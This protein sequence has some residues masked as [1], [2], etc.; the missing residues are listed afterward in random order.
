MTRRAQGHGARRTVVP[1]S[2]MVC[3]SVRNDIRSFKLKSL[4]LKLDF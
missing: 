3:G 4:D 1:L 2:N